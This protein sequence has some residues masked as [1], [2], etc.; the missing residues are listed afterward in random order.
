MPDAR[1]IVRQLNALAA[2]AV[3]RLTVDIHGRLVRPPSAG[4]TPRDTSWA[5]SR[6]IPRIGVGP[7]VP[8]PRPADA[9]PNNSE[10][11]AGL[12]QVIAQFNLAR[13]AT[14]ISNG[15]PY[16]GRLNEGSSQQ[17]PAGFVQRAIAESLPAVSRQLA[18]IARRGGFRR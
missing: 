14:S 2:E 5:A 6:W 7:V 17:A 15:A 12:A 3:V 10:A 8:Q 16:I 9:R 1:E 18:A 11:Q 4:G 13:G